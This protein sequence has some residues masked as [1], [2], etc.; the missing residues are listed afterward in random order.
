MKLKEDYLLCRMW[1]NIVERI[2]ILRVC[3]EILVLVGADSSLMAINSSLQAMTGQK[4]QQLKLTPIL[5]LESQ[6]PSD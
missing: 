1:R 4:Y 3:L 2:P 6:V 5:A